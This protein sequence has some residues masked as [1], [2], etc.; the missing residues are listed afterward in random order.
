[1]VLR[2]QLC[3]AESLRSPALRVWAERL[4]PMWDGGDGD[5][6]VGDGSG[7]GR[8]DI[9]LHRKMWEWLF[10]AEALHERGV[11]AA[12]HRGLGFGVGQEPLT[13]LFAAEGCDV[14][15]SDQPR[16]AAVASG[17]TDSSSEWAGGL[18][19]LNQWG[20]C[21]ADEFARRVRFQE[22]D[23]KAIPRDLRTGAFDFT[24]SSCALEHLGTLAAG[25]DFVV[26]QMDCLKPGGVAVH[27]TEYLVS[28]NDVTVEAG[29]TVFYRRRDIEALAA[30][31]RKLGHDID[32]DYTEGTT[33]EDLHVDVPPYSDVHLRTEL[34]GYVTTSLALVVTKG[35]GR[36]RGR[37]RAMVGRRGDA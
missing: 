19:N 5:S 21:A 23:M 27:T 28:S 35:A 33:P 32:V 16:Q 22:V 26:E 9:M 3:S 15:A 10:V 8:R 2:S 17:W 37:L 7:V 34:A 30:R 25:A 1:M 4:R 20:L 13:A 29:G 12:G 24:W 36:R 6:D 31:L 18:E 14:V 11:L